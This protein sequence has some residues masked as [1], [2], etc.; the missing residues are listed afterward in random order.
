MVLGMA[1]RPRAPSSSPAAVVVDGGGDLLIADAD[2]ERVRLV[3]GSS[4]SSGCPYGLASMTRGDIYT[5]AGDGSPGYSG[6][7]GPATS[8]ELD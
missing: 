2:N 6:D 8:A 5:I 4:C 7:G 3:A 1:G